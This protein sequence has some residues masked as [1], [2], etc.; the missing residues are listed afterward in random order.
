[1]QSLKSWLDSTLYPTFGN[2]WDDK[3]FREVILH[4]VTSD[5]VVLDVG[6]GAGI[7]AD[8]NFRGHV[9][10][11]CGIDLDPRVRT[12][13]FLDESAISTAERIPHPNETFDVVISDNVVEHLADPAAVFNEVA[14]V[15][16]P[17]GRFVFKTPNRRHY[18]ALVA[19]HTPHWFHR[20]FNRHRGRA[21]EDTF[22]TLYRANTRRDIQQA[23]A[24][25]DLSV[26]SLRFVEGRPEYLRGTPVTY[27]AGCAYERLV[28]STEALQQL[29]IVL[30]AVLTKPCKT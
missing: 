18:M 11:I 20:A 6:A 16:K 14:R 1:M 24:A 21:P 17:G 28:N 26:E 5:S 19:R 23:A 9:R 8:M 15:L 25:A 22:P 7:V 3:I 10:R 13:P 30:I 2:N 4:Y 27:L 12:N 29:R